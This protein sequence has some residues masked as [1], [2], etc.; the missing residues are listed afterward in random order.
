MKSTQENDFERRV[1]A[2]W[3]VEGWRDSHV[4][5]G[6]SGGADSVAM[7]RSVLAI[8]TAC[9][10]KGQ[11]FVA[12]F[13]HGVRGAEADADQEW[14]G[15]LCRQ[16]ALPFETARAEPVTIQPHGGGWEAAARTAR[17]D[18][19]LRTAERLGARFVAVAH[20][21]DDQ[22]ETV[23]H[24]ILRGTGL[25]GLAGIRPIRPL[26]PNVALVR[27]LLGTTRPE[28]LAYLADIGQDYRIDQTNRDTR[29]TRNRLRHELL[30]LL[31]ELYNS[32]VDDAL[33]RLALQAGE[34]QEAIAGLAEQLARDCVAMERAPHSPADDK[35]LRVRLK[36]GGLQNAPPIVIREVC[37]AVWHEAGWPMQ[38]M[39]FAEWQAI[40][41]LVQGLRE[42]TVNLPGGVQARRETETVVLEAAN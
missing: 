26:S 38:A 31:R 42:T 25:A 11:L 17:Y 33:R 36:C 16:V 30:P 40:A 35:A 3:P 27:P 34:T 41:E 23:L 22:T 2:A 19:L 37:R 6:V 28:V 29:W 9:G 24:R 18:F 20:T 14:L 12:H 1:A 10:G 13:N 7:L 5:L 21:A 8:K 32:D 4:V 39:G 15:A